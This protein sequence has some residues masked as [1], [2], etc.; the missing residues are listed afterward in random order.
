MNEQFYHDINAL[1]QAGTVCLEEAPRDLDTWVCAQLATRAGE[2]ILNIGCDS[3]EQTL[4]LARTI[5]QDGYVLAIDRSYR[6][7]N[8]LSQR[9]Q[10]SGLEQRIRFL[11]LNLD[12]LA[13]HLRP[14]DFHWAISGRALSHVKQP[15]AVFQ[16]IRQALKPGGIFFFYGLARKD[17]LELRLFHAALRNETRES[18]E[19]LFIEQVG[20]PCTRNVFPRA[21]FIKFECPLRFT[22][23]DALY[24]YWH[25]SELYEE[26]LD[27]DFR[28]ATVQH[29][30]AYAAFETAQ[31]LIG[32]RAING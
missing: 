17:L 3:N 19:L 32:V 18:R 13:G 1:K 2:N 7:L 12:D 28:R 10:A 6:A 11:Y 5:G 14:E 27:K 24:A 22:S 26:A 31:R 25:E 9:S 30:Q 29:F 20:A 23:P 16:A 4:S 15:Q 21:E 8:A